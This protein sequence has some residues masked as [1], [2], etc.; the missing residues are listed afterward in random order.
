MYTTA[1][2]AAIYTRAYRTRLLSCYSTNAPQRRNTMRPATLRF[3]PY[4]DSRS[5]PETRIFPRPLSRR[6]RPPRNSFFSS[7]HRSRAHFYSSIV[8]PLRLLSHFTSSSTRD[9]MIPFL[10][11]FLVFSLFSFFFFS[12]VVSHEI[13]I[14]RVAIA[15]RVYRG[16]IGRI[17][18]H[19]LS[20]GW[21]CLVFFCFF[22]SYFSF[23]F[24]FSSVVRRVR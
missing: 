2:R 21:F 13:A 16:S 19:S 5:R 8:G 7:S 1:R 15:R 6:R 17:F 18:F 3:P 11:S 14:V 22:F 24:C 23:L 9:A 20:G 4:Y 12:F 10:F